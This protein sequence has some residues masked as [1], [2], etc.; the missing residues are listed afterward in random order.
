MKT[1]S[2]YAK[3]IFM[4]PVKLRVSRAATSSDSQG[5]YAFAKRSVSQKDVKP[6]GSPSEDRSIRNRYV[7]FATP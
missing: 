7:Y 3:G 1:A 4:P 5:Q 2:K 6:A